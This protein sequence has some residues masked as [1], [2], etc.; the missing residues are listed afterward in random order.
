MRYLAQNMIRSYGQSSNR[1]WKKCYEKL[2]IVIFEKV[3]MKNYG[4]D[5]RILWI[6][7]QTQYSPQLTFPISPYRSRL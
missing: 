1:Y 4:I 6:F 7:P 2:R 5:R 3:F